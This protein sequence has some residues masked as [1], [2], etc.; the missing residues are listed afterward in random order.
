[1]EDAWTDAVGSVR[2]LYGLDA[3]RKYCA[4]AGVSQGF[5]APNLSDLTRLDSARS[6]EIETPSPDLDPE[7]FTSYEAG[8]KTKLDRFASQIGYYYTSINSMIIRTPTGE[9]VDGYDEVTKKN[10]GNGYVNGVE[11]STCYMLTDEWSTWASGSI[12]YGK[13]DSYPSSTADLQ[14]GYITRLMPPTAQVGLKWS[15][16]D[17]KYWAEMIGD[18]AADADKLSADDRRD[19]QR[20]PPGGTPGYA[21]MHLRTGT[22]ISDSLKLSFALENVFNEDYRIHGSGVNEVGRNFVM[23]ADYVF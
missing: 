12:M 21:V 14:E 17:A 23:T 15:R 2:A 19:T 10:S 3:S 9:K 22:K 6:N 16:T 4:F 8:L 7:H 5:R 18:M 1:M 13:V 20:I 11:L